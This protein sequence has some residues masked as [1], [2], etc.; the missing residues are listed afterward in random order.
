MAAGSVEYI[1]RHRLGFGVIRA[2]C[3][4]SAGLDGREAVYERARTL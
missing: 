2:S 4:P 1:A 3:R